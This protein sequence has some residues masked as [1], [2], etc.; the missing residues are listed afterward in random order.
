MQRLSRD[1]GTWLALCEAGALGPFPRPLPHPFQAE[2][3]TAAGVPFMEDLTGRQFGPYQ[4]VAPLGEGG[5]AAVYQAYQPAVERHVALKVLPRHLA[6]EPDFVARFQRE[7]RVL[8]QLQHPHI[9][10]VF[11]FGQA[12]GY[13]YL[14]MPYI[15]GGTLAAAFTGALAA[16]SRIRQIMTQVGGALQHAHA[17][18]VIHRDVKPSNVMIDEDGHCLL[19]D[20]GLARMVAASVNLTNSGA[21]IGTPAYMSPEQGAGRPVDARSDLYSLGVILYELATGRVPYKAETPIAVIFKHIQ[22]PLPLARSVNPEVP[23]QLELVILK[24]LAKDPD[25]RYQSA[26]D[27]VRAVQAALLDPILTDQRAA[28]PAAGSEIPAVPAPEPAAPR[29]VSARAGR[30]AGA[31]GALLLVV[32][33][34]AYLLRGGFLPNAQPP[35]A[36]SAVTQLGAGAPSATVLPPATATFP[37]VAV[38]V[39]AGTPTSMPAAVS[40]TRLAAALPPVAIPPAFGPPDFPLAGR[41]DP[42]LA[43]QITVTQVS[44]VVGQTAADSYP[45]YIELGL[46]GY[47]VTP[48]LAG[49]PF[50]SLRIF[51]AAEYLTLRPEHQPIVEAFRE[52]RAG[53]SPSRMYYLV[54]TAW[55]ARSQW[56]KFEGGVGFGSLIVSAVAGQ[57]PVTN[58]NLQYL[59]QGLTD[60]DRLILAVLPLRALGLPDSAADGALTSDQN[61]AYNAYLAQVMGTLAELPASQFTPDLDVLTRFFE[62]LEVSST[63]AGLDY[64]SGQWIDGPALNFE[65]RSDALAITLAD[66]RVLV[67]GGSVDQSEFAAA[68]L[69]YDPGANAWSSAGLMSTAHIGGAAARLADGQVLVAGGADLDGLVQSQ[70]ERY[71]PATG[72]WEPAAPMREARQ[73]FNLVTLPAGRLLAIGGNDG[74]QTLSSAEIYDPASNRWTATGAM[75]VERENFA[76][77]VIPGARGYVMAAGGWSPG[78]TATAELYDPATGQW[79]LTANTMSLGRLFNHLPVLPDGRVIAIGGWSNGAAVSAVDIYDPGTNRWRPGPPLLTA[80]FAYQAVALP[81]GHIVVA[82]GDSYRTEDGQDTLATAEIYTPAT[83]EWT[84]LPGQMRAPRRDITLTVL[85]DGRL[86]VTGGR[87]DGDT[88]YTLVD[89]F[90]PGSK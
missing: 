48:T 37:P 65:G 45:A 39:D 56:F 6:S 59:F 75:N 73:S 4:I 80:R 19:S 50:P 18:G 24:A 77:A 41:F 35:T 78:V 40:P 54:S 49:R 88:R 32:G 72:R 51:Q 81:D 55:A 68:T 34:A 70:A 66:G 38:V 25:S 31:V 89:I 2:A 16:P 46:V 9:L 82:G 13:S 5:M 62:A 23:E 85:S 29:P 12:D 60:D 15:R 22:D 69:L 1:S 43:A 33:L 10:P 28:S 42:T 79:T 30:W 76:A 7:A 83:S 87:D 53:Q 11:D 63:A 67:G 52:M 36:S 61:A 21:M 44:A 90:V 17:H 71:N 86:L 84:R 64:G 8:A 3:D 14:V 27:L 20:F 74:R 47:P 57:P 58:E 26:D